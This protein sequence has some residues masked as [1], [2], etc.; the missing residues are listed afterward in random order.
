MMTNQ[1]LILVHTG[2]Q[3]PR[4][5]QVSGLLLRSSFPPWIVTRVSEFGPAP[6]PVPPALTLPA[7]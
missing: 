3:L 1:V 4:P 5:T 7:I 2:Q 6:S